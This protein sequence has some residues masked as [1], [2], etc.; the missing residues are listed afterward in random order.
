V[1][2][3]AHHVAP[4]A[5]TL[6]LLLALLHLG[7]LGHLLLVCLGDKRF[8]ARKL[9]ALLL[10]LARNL[11]GL[12]TRKVDLA[13][14][15]RGGKGVCVLGLRSGECPHRQSCTATLTSRPASSMRFFF[16]SCAPFMA[17]YTPS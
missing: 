3:Q 7:N 11:L 9:V 8:G 13:L 4:S 2:P 14:L 17:S 1:S 15:R 6:L 12:G 10:A 16:A 5:L